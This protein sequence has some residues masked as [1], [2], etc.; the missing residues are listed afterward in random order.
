MVNAMAATRRAVCGMRPPGYGDGS[1][2][3]PIG[4]RDGEL[5]I[6]RHRAGVVSALNSGWAARNSSSV[7]FFAAVSMDSE[8]S[9]SV[10]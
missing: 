9:S 2:D 8:D 7:P 6:S 5:R 10:S 1:V 3:A 4:P